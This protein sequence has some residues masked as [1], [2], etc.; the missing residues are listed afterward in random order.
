MSNW[1]NTFHS[2]T[3]KAFCVL[4]AVWILIEYLSYH[5][6]FVNA[7]VNH[8]YTGLLLKIGLIIGAFTGYFEYKRR[9]SP[10]KNLE[11]KYRGVVLFA[12]TMAFAL[13]ILTAYIPLQGKMATVDLGTRLGYFVVF[14]SILLVAMFFIFLC[15]YGLGKIILD[16]LPL[17]YG[18]ELPV[19]SIALGFSV[20]GF[21]LLLLAMAGLMQP[22]I[23]WILIGGI[24][25][26]GIRQNAQFAFSVFLKPQVVKLQSV[27]SIPVLFIVLLLS[28]T[29]LISA[30]KAYPVGYDGTMLYLNQANLI[31]DYGGL[32]EGGDA[33][34]WAL[35]MSLGQI[36]FGQPTISILLSHLMGLACFFGI[37]FV[38]RKWL[39][40]PYALLAAAIPYMSQYFGFHTMSDEKT[41]LA[42]LF[43]GI[44][45]FLFLF[46]QEEK[47]GG[48]FKKIP[49]SLISWGL[50]GW[51]AGYAFGIKYTGLLLLISLGSIAFFRKGKEW[52]VLGYFLLALGGLF[53]LGVYRLAYLPLSPNQAHI[54]GAI[55]AVGGVVSMGAF[56]RKPAQLKSNIIAVGFMLL[57]AVVCYAPWAGRNISQRIGF[58]LMEMSA[59]RDLGP[60]IV[61]QPAGVADDVVDSLQLLFPRH[62]E[63]L[64]ARQEGGDSTDF[65]N[66][67]RDSTA[68]R[69][70]NNFTGPKEAE[71]LY[72][73]GVYEEIMRY[74]GYEDGVLLYT[75][76]P[77][78][79]TTNANFVG[80]NPRYLDI[81]FLFL[82]ILPLLLMGIPGIKRSWLI[83]L[84]LIPTMLAWVASN[85]FAQYSKGGIPNAADIL[86]DREGQFAAQP[87]GAGSFFWHIYEFLLNGFL[88]LMEALSGVFALGV[89]MP[90][91]AGFFLLLLLFLGVYLLFRQ[92]LKELDDSFKTFA[93]FLMIY[94]FSWLI[95]GNAIVW[96]GFVFWT[97][98]PILIVYFVL[99]PEKFMGPLNSTFSRV[100]LSG[101]VALFLFGGTLV[102]LTS[103]YLG[104][105]A[106]LLFPW[107]MVD[108]ATNP[109]T[110]SKQVLRNYNPFF[111]KAL[112]ALNSDV[113]EKIYSVNTY[114][115]YHI[116]ENDQRVYNDV[117]LAR[118][119]EITART[120]NDEAFIDVLKENGYKYILYD[121]GTPAVD[122]TPEKTLAEKCGRLVNLFIQS[123]KL[124]LV[125]TDNYVIDNEN[126]DKWV[127]LPT[128]E[129]FRGR[130]DLVGQVITPGSF[131]LYKI[132]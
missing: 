43:F 92:R 76:I 121:L 33:F 86:A 108:F 103:P 100:F 63:K 118:F 59:S 31:S 81:G 12:L 68:V 64:R 13:L 14:V 36:L 128:G 30:V 61:F 114:L 5:P 22:I 98:L 87:G 32:P 62:W 25:A 11:I 85:Y 117:V 71:P 91:A 42:F 37:F 15:A 50:A 109:N 54:L 95:L 97:L 104:R 67:V 119:G 77:Y 111:D 99:H 9:K 112:T 84:L 88:Q 55:L 105:T 127:T 24:F 93:V 18:P 106:D 72:D 101:T 80:G 65:F 123:D 79:M 29:Y 21:L 122:Q 74:L 6:Y 131:A 19:L 94:G 40:A 51:V 27:W 10:K 45:S 129:K 82:A 26:L 113:S 69:G 75:S 3:I 44:A 120:G 125:V 23:I 8:P 16:R 96:Y 56:R 83:N 110:T 102:S 126:G 46:P 130:G 41:D 7:I 73:Q 57:M 78:D 60:D 1:Q 4:W 89:A 124:E 70:V 48:T 107:Q 20:L 35:I 38:A 132:K 52:A 49:I 115:R 34:N 39:S 28:A 66:D 53:L 90:F 47:E 58:N 17:S 2:L 116:K